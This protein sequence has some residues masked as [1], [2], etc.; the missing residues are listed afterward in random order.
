MSKKE[1]AVCALADDFQA[2]IAIVPKLNNFIK[3]HKEITAG[4]QK[5]R[6]NGGEAISGI[7][8]YLGAK[9]QESVA[10]AKKKK[11]APVKKVEVSEKGT[12]AK[13]TKKKSKK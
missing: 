11:T 9:E 13:K 8:K 7:E 5:Y 2:M 3:V 1:K 12:E 6:K 10:P 4:Y